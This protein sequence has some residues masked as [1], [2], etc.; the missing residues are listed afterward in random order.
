MPPKARFTKEE[1]VKTAFDM[2]RE[3]GFSS[4]TA[5]GLGNRLGSSSTPVFTVFKN[6]REVQYEVRKLAMKEF[7]KYVADATCYTPAFKQ[8]GMQ[9]IRF[10]KEEP[11]L[12]RILYLEGYEEEQTFDVMFEALGE[13]AK[14]CIDV[15][16]NDYQV[17]PEEAKTIF[18]QTWISTFSICVLLV[19][20][21]CYFSEEE[22]MD[23][24]GLEFQGTLMLIKSGQYKKI[25]IASDT[26]KAPSEP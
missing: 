1:I 26:T 19:N 17:T 21:I 13:Q 24:L 22:I 10:A 7:E 25:G 16:Q 11:Q 9:M 6:M 20:K 5:R 4:V 2:T 23:M 3:N 8:F 18:R 15:I 12:F 14:V